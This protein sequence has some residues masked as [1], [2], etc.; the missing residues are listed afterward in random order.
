LL[1][2]DSNPYLSIAQVKKM[3]EQCSA[4][5]HV[6]QFVFND[7]SKIYIDYL[8]LINFV[9]SD[10]SIPPFYLTSFMNTALAAFSATECAGHENF[11]RNAR[12]AIVINSLPANFQVG[13]V[14]ETILEKYLQD[15]ASFDF[16]FVLTKTSSTAYAQELLLKLQEFEI[17]AEIESEPSSIAGN[18]ISMPQFYRTYFTPFINTILT[19]G[20]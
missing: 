7:G 8:G 14:K 12:N 6:D 17:E 5:Q 15:V 16:P 18:L 4:V 11:I 20:T 1:G 10:H 3:E 13:N 9:S 19:Y 2:G